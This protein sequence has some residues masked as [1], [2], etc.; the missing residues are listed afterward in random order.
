LARKVGYL[1]LVGDNVDGVSH[2]PGQEK[3]LIQKTSVGQYAKV[4]EILKL[5]RKD[6]KIIICP[7]QHD[8]VWIGEPQ[9]I[10]PEKWAP[11]LYKMENVTLVPNPAWVEI[12][13]G[14]KVLMY[15]GASLNRFIDE[16]PD[17]RTNFGHSSPTRVV[18]EILKRRHLAP[19]HGL[20]DYIP[21]EK[22]DPLVLDPIPDIFA[23]ADQHRAEVAIH[24]NILLVA[25]SCWQSITPFEE[26]VGNIPDPCKVPLFNL[27]TR[28]IKLLDFSD[29]PKEIEWQIGEGLSCQVKDCPSG[30][31][32]V[33][34]Q[35]CVEVIR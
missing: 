13:G 11:E 6:V 5:I 12:D 32:C 15:H 8:S 7:G 3:F 26:K 33:K 14:F 23:T 10:I 35:P 27:K 21:C 22:G 25:S 9:P 20:M 17:I 16:I 29:A 18:K 2:Y 1:F 34:E 4:A 24:N 31:T 19:I 30:E 28:E